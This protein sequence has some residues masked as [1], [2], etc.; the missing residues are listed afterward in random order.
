ML[1]LLPSP[2]PL[3]TPKGKAWAVAVIDCGPHLDRVWVTFVHDSG[4]CCSFNNSE[5]RKEKTESYPAVAS[6][7]AVPPSGKILPFHAR[8]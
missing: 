6:M 3:H 1:T 2:L 8:N 4:K 7:P 5:I